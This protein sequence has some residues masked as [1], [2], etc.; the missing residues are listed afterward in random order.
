MCENDVGDVL[1]TRE[2]KLCGIVTDRDIVVR[3]VAKGEDPA[4]MRIERICSKQVTTLSPDDEVDDAVEQMREHAVRRIP[5][6]E[7]ERIVGIVSLGDLAQERDP[8][9]ALGAISSA[10]ANR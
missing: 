3:C 5:V 8:R 6:M 9:S 7:K 10:P 1:V 4:K 2:G